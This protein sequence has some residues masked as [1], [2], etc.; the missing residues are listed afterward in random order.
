MFLFLAYRLYLS[1]TSQLS[2]IACERDDYQRAEFIHT[3]SQ[4]RRHQLLF[5]DESSKD[6]RTPER[7]Y[8]YYP[9]GT[10]RPSGL[11]NFIRKHRVSIM[12]AM[13]QNGVVGSIVVEG[14]FDSELFNFVAQ[15]TILNSLG[16]CVNNEPRSVVVLDNCRIHDDDFIELIRGVGAIV[17]FLPPYSPDFNPVE[18]EF[19]Q[20]KAW[21][22]R[23][24]DY[25]YQNPKMALYAA[26][27]E[28]N[29]DLAEYFFDACG[30]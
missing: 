18:L 24:R 14:S 26:V 7:R 20:I 4:F 22:K 25:V 6:D 5:L 12:S 17:I 15:Q 9:K 2:V 30:Y 23:H 11:G 21:L 1:F 27:D 8:G 13:D 29:N 28:I 3:I 19:R 16:I 10:R